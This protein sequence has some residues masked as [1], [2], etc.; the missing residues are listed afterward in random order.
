[1]ISQWGGAVFPMEDQTERLREMMNSNHAAN[2]RECVL[3]G[4][5]IKYIL[6]A[7]LHDEDRDVLQSCLPLLGSRRES[8]SPAE[9][10]LMRR[11]RNLLAIVDRAYQIWRV[12]MVLFLFLIVFFYLMLCVLSWLSV[13]CIVASYI[14]SL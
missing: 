13:K 12:R 10:D 3:L 11:R 2:E 6:Q 8:L 1:M 14:N 4:P 5:E 9:K 7:G